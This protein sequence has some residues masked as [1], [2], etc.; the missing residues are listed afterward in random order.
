MRR[1]AGIAGA[2]IMHDTGSGQYAPEPIAALRVA[3]NRGL[4]RYFGT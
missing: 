1:G 2:D 3:R 4:S